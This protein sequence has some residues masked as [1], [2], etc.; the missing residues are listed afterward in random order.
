[1]TRP[2]YWTIV[3][4]FEDAGLTIQTF[5]QT[6]LINATDCDGVI[7]SY[8]ASTGTAIFRDGNGK[9]AKRNTQR[10]FPVKRFI[11]LCKDNSIEDIQEIFF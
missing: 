2:E 5:P 4:E 9:W 6:Y 1:M 8:Y 11:A 7:Q 10:D 3:R